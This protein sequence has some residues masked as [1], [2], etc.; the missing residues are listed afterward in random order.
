MA[1]AASSNVSMFLP[2]AS[3]WRREVVR[4]L[5][6]RSRVIGAL[7]TP[8]VFWLLIGSG[9]RHALS[10]PGG[11]DRVDYMEYAFPGTIVLIVLFTSIFSMISIIEDRREGFLQGVLVAPIR[12]SSIVFGKLLGGS[13]L[14]V[15]QAGLFL[16]LAPFIGAPLTPISFLA[17]LAV[18]TLVSFGLGALGFLIAWKLDSTQG[19]H[20][21]MNLVLMP[22]W[23][24]SGAFFP[25]AGA[26]GWI[27]LLM[28]INPL[29][30]GVAC[31]RHVL[32]WGNDAVAAELPDFALCLIVTALATIVAIAVGARAI[33]R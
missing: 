20:A 6:Q 30:Y 11:G 13:S 33:R 10:L 23:L 17:A 28:A 15:L 5:R 1:I 4:F 12:R 26:A 32:Y 24:L 14:A 19:F 9:L 29:T 21:I 7:G 31:L 18:I 27:K 16:L 25:A 22:M 3:L 8:V 2:A